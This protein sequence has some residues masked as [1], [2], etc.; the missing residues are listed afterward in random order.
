MHCL[1]LS[2][3]LNEAKTPMPT[4]HHSPPILAVISEKTPPPMTGIK[5]IDTE[6]PRRGGKTG[7]A[8]ALWREKGPGISMA[9]AQIK[10]RRKRITPAAVPSQGGGKE[11]MLAGDHSPASII[12]RT[13]S[14]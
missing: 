3:A 10:S 6:V 5:P 12:G 1:L 2:R 9:I 14:D 7:A 11:M 8:V 13:F 4:I